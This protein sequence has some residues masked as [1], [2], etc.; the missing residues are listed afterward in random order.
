MLY[1]KTTSKQMKQTT[2]ILI[3]VSLMA[4]MLLVV[5]LLRG[6]QLPINTPAEQRFP[7]SSQQAKTT[8]AKNQVAPSATKKN[9]QP[10]AQH[11][12][13]AAPVQVASTTKVMS[14]HAQLK[15]SVAHEYEYHL[16]TTTP[17]DPQYTSDWPLQKTNA[18]AGWAIAS[19]NNQTVVA[20]IDSGFALAHQDLSNQWATNADEVGMTQAGGLCWTGTSVSKQT[21]NCDDDNNGYSDD[22]R[23]WNFA[24]SDNNP[25][26]GR[27]DA[28]GDGVTHGTEV[29][30]LVG[31]TGNNGLGSTAINQATKIMPLQA[32][33]DDGTGYTSDVAAAIYYATDNGA[34][35]I[36]MSL[37]GYSEDPAMLTAIDYAIANNVVVIA[38]AGNCGDGTGS[39][40]SGQPTG[41]ISYPAAYPAVI[42]VGATTQSDTRASFS[43]YGAALDVVAPGYNL[44]TSTTWS[45]GN[46]TSLYTGSLFGTSFASPQVASLASLIRSIRPSSSVRDVTAL[47][48]ASTSKPSGMSGLP[49]TQ[50]F[51]HGVINVGSSLT[52]AQALNTTSPGTVQLL[53]TGSY[54]AEHVTPNNTQL[55]SGCTVSANSACTI[56]L[57]N[58]VSGYQRYLPYTVASSGTADW[59]WS[60]SILDGGEWEIRALGGDSLSNT[61]YAL[62]KN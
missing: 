16:L 37:G 1:H 29:T 33:D 28:N 20:V 19:G 9:A 47:I 39:S 61:P 50:Q 46:P 18:S 52:V 45:A 24:M 31:A 59:T 56:M 43:S 35:V 58:T 57:T 36:N 38:A 5:Y 32:L 4:A 54:E 11:Q 25:Q 41:A 51:G 7:V 12:V 48:L 13:V 27:T 21:N 17:N 44:P 49:Y 40:C 26:T 22:W 42:A 55:S 62:L 8:F 23:G 2:K 14:K 10:S 34:Q 3:D 53:Q 6:Q 30:G 15:H 60:S